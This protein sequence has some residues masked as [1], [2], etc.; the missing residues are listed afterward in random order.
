MTRVTLH[1]PVPRSCVKASFV[2]SLYTCCLW[3]FVDLA[4]ITTHRQH[5]MEARINVF[6]DKCDLAIQ[7]IKKLKM[8]A[9][10]FLGR[11]N[12]QPSELKER[13]LSCMKQLDEYIYLITDFNL[14]MSKLDST[15]STNSTPVLDV[16]NRP[17]PQPPLETFNLIDALSEPTPSTSKAHPTACCNQY[18][19]EKPIQKKIPK[20]D[21]LLIAFSSASCSSESVP[22]S[23]I[24]KEVQCEIVEETKKLTLDDTSLAVEECK[25]PA[26][27]LLQIDH[28]YPA[29]IM[30]VDGLSFW[31][32][33]DDI[34]DVYK[35]MI[36]MTS[37]YK[38]NRKQL[39]L[40]EVMALTYCSY[41]DDES[42]CYYRALFIRL[43][44][45]DMSVA[46]VFLVDTG[47]TRCASIATIQPLDPIF[48]KKPPFA[49]C[50]H[51]AGVDLLGY[52][53]KE[54]LEKQELFLKNYM[55]EQCNIKIDD[56]YSSEALDVYVILPSGDTIN[57]LLVHY[58]LALKIDK[59]NVSADSDAA[60]GLKELS[61]A[62]FDITEGPEYEDP[63]V[64]VTG[65]HSRDEMDIC[66]HYKGGPEK[67][68]YKGFRCTKRH[69]L[70]H[71]DGWT[72]DR[73]PVAARCRARALPPPGSWARAHVTH[74]A[75]FN[76]FY[77]HF[78]DDSDP[79]LV[80]ITENM[81]SPSFGVVLPPTNLN[82]LI[83][84]M[85]SPATRLTYKPLEMIPAPGELVA[86]LYPPD[87]QW[88][89]ARVISSTRTDQSVEVIYIDYGNVV[90]V[91]E[92]AVR[93][94]E[95]R[96][97]ALEAQASRCVLAG[98]TAKTSDS[99]Q[100]AAAKNALHALIHEQRLQVH[101]IARHYDE[102]T[103]ELF[104]S[105]GVNIAELLADQG[106]V[107]LTEYD[108]D[109]D[110]NVKQ[111]LVIP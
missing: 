65:Y 95:P 69:V 1:G 83:L 34:D 64:A 42:D 62:N 28:I 45:D 55:G 97:W 14:A 80:F 3:S 41:Y 27:T 73:V 101:V 75:H 88:Y 44:E 8:Q 76:R 30:H 109:D 12:C 60:R 103:V 56:K 43:T 66:K 20:E 57:D 107:K 33:A 104:D 92:N 91:K 71:P 98:V 70:K 50:C 54:L 7:D 24:E 15:I 21:Q 100:W 89:R 26:Q 18:P 5:E 11:L 63:L 53:S 40:D 31:V 23:K 4:T 37:Y 102:V 96:F 22:I 99:S 39:K 47:E 85:N 25:L 108:I 9:Q 67:T 84:D 82:S 13:F 16:S 48:C 68:C 93:Q 35:L 72:R 10:S 19:S 77:V 90:W 51:F 49:R 86:A 58:G 111:K 17:L 52:R 2:L 61:E 110:T 78:L 79:A 38:E 74:V 36:Q 87:E 81:P 105:E 29:T 59:S 94:L 106:F 6:A 46:E 32:I